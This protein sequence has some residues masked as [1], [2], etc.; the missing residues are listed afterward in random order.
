MM[1]WHLVHWK[2]LMHAG[3]DIKVIGFDA[4]DDAVKSVEDGK[5]AGTVA[6]KPE[7]IGKKAV[8]AAVQSLKGEDS[9]SINSS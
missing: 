6:Q 4:T 2:Q 3:K 8:E 1:R 7:L 9:R 5:L